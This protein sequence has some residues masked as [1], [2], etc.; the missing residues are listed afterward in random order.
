MGSLDNGIAKKIKFSISFYN[1]ARGHTPLSIWVLGGTAPLNLKDIL[2]WS[3]TKTKNPAFY[4]INVVISISKTEFSVQIGI[5][6]G[7]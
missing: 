7:A 1:R 2:T 6:P 3:R 4:K 5:K